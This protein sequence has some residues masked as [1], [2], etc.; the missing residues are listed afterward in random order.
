MFHHG[1]YVLVIQTISSGYHVNLIKWEPNNPSSLT[2]IRTHDLLFRY[3]MWDVCEC[4]TLV[5]ILQ[6]YVFSHT[7]W[8]NSLR[9]TILV[10][11]Y[12]YSYMVKEFDCAIN[13]DQWPWHFKII[14]FAKSR[15]V[16]CSPVWR[17]CVLLSK[18]RSTISSCILNHQ[19][20]LTNIEMNLSDEKKLYC[21]HY[22][23]FR[24]KNVFTRIVCTHSVCSCLQFL[25]LN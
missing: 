24:K 3:S 12:V 22:F 9:V 13:F 4:F 7:F 25:S 19:G 17:F 20:N 1:Y 16:L 23:S 18:N 2:Q 14:T 8:T 10:S 15:G 21:K 5:T 11:T 6:I